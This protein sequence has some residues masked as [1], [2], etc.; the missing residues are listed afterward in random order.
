MAPS[1]C[2]EALL[3]ISS[4]NDFLWL[5]LVRPSHTSSLVVQGPFVIGTLVLVY[6]F[7][8][9]PSNNSALLSWERWDFTYSSS[10][11]SY[12]TV[13]GELYTTVSSLA[14]TVLEEHFAKGHSLQCPNLSKKLRVKTIAEVSPEELPCVHAALHKLRL[15]SQSSDGVSLIVI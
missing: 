2:I 6:T 7:G 8:K 3:D 11:L 10:Y 12:M 4:I 1:M 15:P 13:N 14:P 5:R 9:V